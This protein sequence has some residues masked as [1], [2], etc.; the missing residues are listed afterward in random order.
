MPGHFRS[1]TVGASCDLV[2]GSPRAVKN[3]M[4]DLSLLLLS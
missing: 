4:F 1:V 2:F 3:E